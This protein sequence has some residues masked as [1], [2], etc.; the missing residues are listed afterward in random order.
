ED[1]AADPLQYAF[2]W[3]DDGVFDTADQPSNIAAQRFDRLGSATVAV[4]VRDDDGGESIG[5]TSVTVVEHRVYL[6]LTAR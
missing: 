1:V 2:D 6:P 3:N 4:R 5:G